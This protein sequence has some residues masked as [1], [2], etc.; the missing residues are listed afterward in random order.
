MRIHVKEKGGYYTVYQDAGTFLPALLS[1]YEDEPVGAVGLVPCTKADLES[2]YPGAEFIVYSEGI[3]QTENKPAKL[4][5]S[6]A[7]R[8]SL[9]AEAVAK[10]EREYTA[11]VLAEKRKVRAFAKKEG[12]D[13]KAE[14]ELSETATPPLTGEPKKGFDMSALA[15]IASAFAPAEKKETVSEQYLEPARKSALQEFKILLA[16]YYADTT[17]QRS[18]AA[19]ESVGSFILTIWPDMLTDLDTAKK[20]F[21]KPRFSL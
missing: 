2:Q 12:L 6:E 20:G 3:V 9:S 17:N 11:K 14:G 5:L 7:Q 13:L 1:S 8:E 21:E 4:Q 19:V 15:T 18:K 10:L 16:Q